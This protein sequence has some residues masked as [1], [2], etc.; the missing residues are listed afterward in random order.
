MS[1]YLQKIF[2][3]PLTRGNP[4]PSVGNKFQT[5]SP[6]DLA[7]MFDTTGSMYGHLE[8]VR[9]ELSRLA[10]EIHNAIPNARLA[11]IAY[12]D[13]GDHYVTKVLEFTDQYNCVKAFVDSVGRTSGG[14]APEAVEEALFRA[15]Q[16]NW[17]I[18]SSRAVVLVGDAPPHGVV[19]PIKQYDYRA[20][21]NGLGQKGVKIYATQCGSDAGTERVFKW[22]AANTKGTYL[23]LENIRD[24]VDLLVGI[25]MKEVGLLEAYTAKL[26]A[27]GQLIG[28]KANVF[29]QLTDRSDAR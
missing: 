20:E 18:G 17:R 12:G 5:G 6:L 16:L 8:E 19:D 13:Y 7:L 4:Q 11:V 1:K 21:S 27:G 25:C 3:G 14:D 26:A 2:D 9:R 10:S 28:S 15:N 24:L 23:R 22:M 29:K